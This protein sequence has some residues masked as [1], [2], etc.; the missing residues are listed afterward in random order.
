MKKNIP[1]IITGLNFIAGL[2][3]IYFCSR[4]NILHASYSIFLAMIFDFLD[5]MFA[6]ALKSSSDFGKQ[7]DS[8]A[9]LVSFGIVPGFIA[10]NLLKIQVELELT[11]IQ[12]DILPFIGFL[13][14]LFSAIRLAKFNIDTRQTNVFLG[15]PTPAHALFWASIPIIL[16][17]TNSESTYPISNVFLNP[18][19][20]LA[21]IVL[22]SSMMLLNIEMISLKFNNLRVKEN[23]S[24]Y[25]LIIGVIVMFIC[26]NLYALPLIIV[27]YTLLSVVFSIIIRSKSIKI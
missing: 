4:G 24:R 3:G 22:F 2:A 18:Y 9:D 11:V 1:N 21:A 13:I 17:F 26:L 25:L 19:F 7:F 15:L 23:F 14:P 27:F 12:K 16:N 6:R 5:G 20:T 10:F 8:L